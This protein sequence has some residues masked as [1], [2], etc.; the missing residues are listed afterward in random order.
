MFMF[1]SRVSLSTCRRPWSRRSGVPAAI[2]ASHR[3]GDAAPTG[4]CLWRRCRQPLRAGWLLLALFGLPVH[5]ADESI[6][7][8]PLNEPMPGGESMFTRLP[9]THT[10]IDFRIDVDAE[11][12]RRRLYE[13][14][15]AGAGIAVGDFDNDGRPDIFM[16]HHTGK[17]RL[18]RQTGTLEFSDVTD[19]AG[20]GGKIEWSAGASFVDINND[21]LLDLYVCHYDARNSLFINLGDGRFSDMAADYGLDFKGASVMAAFADYDRDGDLDVYLLTSQLAANAE[22]EQ[23]AQAAKE[24]GPGGRLRPQIPAAGREYADFIERPNG[25]FVQIGAGQR[26]RLYRNDNGV[27]MEVPLPRS[28]QSANDNHMGMSAV[29]WD[30]DHDNWPDLYV[31]NDLFGPDRLYRNNG[32]GTFTDVIES[33]VPHTPWF[34]MGADF[35]DINNDGLFDLIATDMAATTHYDQKIGMGDMDTQGW[36]LTSASPKQYMRN[37]L[38]LNSGTGRF[39]EAAYLAGLA[40][41][42]WTWSAKFADFDNDGF[43]DVFV[44]N[45]M[46]RNFMDADVQRRIH[47]TPDADYWEILKD[48]PAKRDTNLVFRN[49]N[50]L[51]FENRAQE[52]GLAHTGLSFAA[53]P[54]DLDRDG[55]LDLIVNNLDEPVSVYRNNSVA[56]GRVLVRLQGEQSNV[57][58]IGAIVR[59]ET[60]AGLQ[61]RQLS[62]ARGFMSADEPVLHFGTGS[63]SMVRKL[64][65][66]W[67]SGRTQSYSDLP[68]GAQYLIPEA[69]ADDVLP[70][71]D[72]PA[73]VL[74]EDVTVS[75]NLQHRHE[76]LEFDDY[77]VQPLLPAKMSQLGPGA[78]WG[79]ADGDGDDDLFV[80]GAA[81]QAGVLYLNDGQGQFQP[82]WD[83]PWLAHEHRE[84][85]GVLWLDVDGDGDFDLLVASGGVEEQSGGEDL[86][87]RLYLNDGKGN[88][89]NAPTGDFPQAAI[90]SGVMAASDFDLDGDLDL[91]VGGRTV[92]GQYPLSPDSRLL[93]NSGGVFVDVTDEIAPGLRKAGMVTAALWSD[94]DDDNDQDLLLTVEWGPIRY[95]QNAD[96]L[97]SQQTLAA[98]LA[99]RTG[100]WNGIAGL[101]VDN[102]GDT[103]YVV[104]NA[105]LNSKYV[106]SHDKPAMLYYGDFTE[107]GERNLVEAQWEDETVF[108]VRGR[109]CSTGA[110]PF[111]ADEFG[112]FDAF[113]RADI[114]QLFSPTRLD[115]AQMFE[116][117][118]LRS[119]VLINSGNATFEFRPLPL[120]AQIAPGFGIASG[121]F[122]LDGNCD[123]Y[124]VQNS[125][126]PQAETGRMDGGL[127]V[128]LLG[129]GDGNFDPVWPNKSG[130][131]VAGDAKA[132]TTTDFDG[133][134]RADFLITRND[135]TLLAYRNEHAAPAGDTR[136]LSVRLVGSANNPTAIGAKIY[137]FRADG[138]RQSA[139]IYA[140]SGYLS[141]SAPIAFF[142]SSKANP[143]VETIVRWPNGQRSTHKSG[144]ESQ[145]VIRLP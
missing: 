36:F 115:A 87:D 31:S 119:G 55:D 135:D 54:A 84:D 15:F 28:Q 13:I 9:A 93:R 60:A 75:S 63:E 53:T 76:E 73:P 122:D 59:I 45:G 113:A 94:A 121:D 17:D 116:A 47:A 77:R 14:A 114:E 65:V 32:D 58:G 50:G 12:P 8:I 108:P 124:M 64:T 101:D 69:A 48:Q 138:S 88:F 104:T 107:T 72:A 68:V 56:G 98:G 70:A 29:W 66:Q 18:Y 39:M 43:S 62:P 111:L 79:D 7:S 117:T 52:W 131:V 106:A 21:G 10:G 35:A 81:G 25:Q 4:L 103:D 132:L 44:T 142:A 91:F 42:D 11:H 86:R 16:T 136:S 80:G 20:L 37:A 90:S 38:Y 61:I 137:V 57:N 105:G 139:E 145:Q 51:Q 49:V 41:T 125:F 126:A 83:G 46:V 71:A 23:Q 95:F 26:D 85:M 22:A 99:E 96:G 34:S 33:A 2:P 120:L 1:F 123:L 92:P 6:S 133:D 89:E 143:V 134:G 141:Q 24:H 19:A 30:Y 82:E 100:W 3:G 97:L 40:S 67:P 118:E 112:T 102:D 130:L 109:S 110:M 144:D 128:L 5:A 140:G 127:S 74:Y 78:A 27:F 129:N